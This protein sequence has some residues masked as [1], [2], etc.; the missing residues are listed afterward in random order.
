MSRMTEKLQNAGM[1]GR[2]LRKAAMARTLFE[3]DL[4]FV[5]LTWPTGLWVASLLTI[6]PP[7]WPLEIRWV[8]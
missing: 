2:R 3:L 8:S 4:L 7:T 5:L 1:S 6:A